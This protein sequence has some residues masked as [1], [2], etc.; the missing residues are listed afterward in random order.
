M[1]PFATLA[2]M[3]SEPTLSA[4]R[5]Y[6]ARNVLPGRVAS[7]PTADAPSTFGYGMT[8]NNIALCFLMRHIGF[9]LLLT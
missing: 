1:S 6:G 8:L 3:F 9:P 5:A 7:R 2:L 4:R